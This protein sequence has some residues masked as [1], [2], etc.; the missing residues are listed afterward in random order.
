[1]LS[2]II[3]DSTEAKLAVLEGTQAI[4]ALEASIYGAIDSGVLESNHI[5]YEK[6]L[7]FLQEA[8][9]IQKET[10][11]TDSAKIEAYKNITNKAHVLGNELQSLTGIQN[12]IE[13]SVITT[14]NGEKP[15]VTTS[16]PYTPSQLLQAESGIPSWFL[17][18]GIG[19]AIF[20]VTRK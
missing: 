3:F 13:K 11:W 15:K 2:G 7:K 5:L 1:M 16:D 14:S 12:R 17:I 8:S 10:Y 18:A 6:F 19:L 4:K 9:L 20:L